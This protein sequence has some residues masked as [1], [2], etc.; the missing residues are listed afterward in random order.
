MR[1]SGYSINLIMRRG[2]LAL[3]SFCMMVAMGIAWGSVGG[4][5]AAP[6]ATA[7]YAAVVTSAAGNAITSCSIV[8]W[9]DAT[10]GG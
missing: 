3:Q 7:R 10:R 1:L 5:G 9:G 8:I 4:L 2:L 6:I